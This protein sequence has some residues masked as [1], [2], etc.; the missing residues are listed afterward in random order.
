MLCHFPVISS[1]LEGC[2]IGINVALLEHTKLSNTVEALINE[3]Y[4]HST[5]GG[6][7]AVDFG[8][9][10]WANL[11]GQRGHVSKL[12]VSFRCAGTYPTCFVVLDI[13]DVLRVPYCSLGE[14]CTSGK[15]L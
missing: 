9:L 6:K 15:L 13:W 3:V 14:F 4:P 2:S 11:P 1:S 5:V 12:D 7:A 10:T 8:L